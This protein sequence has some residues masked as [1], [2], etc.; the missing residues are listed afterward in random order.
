[1]H[2]EAVGDFVGV[3]RRAGAFAAAFSRRKKSEQQ[4]D[5]EEAHS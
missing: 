4:T 1:V 2:L 3:L 5:G